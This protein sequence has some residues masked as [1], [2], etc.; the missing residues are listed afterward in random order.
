MID[1][2]LEHKIDHANYAGFWVRFFAGCVDL[3]IY[4]P[5]YYGILYES[6]ILTHHTGSSIDWWGQSVF[7]LTALF[8]YPF[9]L[10]NKWQASPGMYLFNFHIC[11]PHGQR[12][13]YT[14]AFIWGI[15]GSIGWVI[16]CAGVIY[17]QSHFDLYVIRDLMVSCTEQNVAP[18][19][20]NK[21]IETIV[22]MP[23]VN[24]IQIL[25][26]SL[27]LMIFLLLIWALSIGLAKDKTGFNNLLC[28]TRFVKGRA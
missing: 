2:I 7:L 23:F 28:G 14:R 26:A 11:T 16:C 13:T 15:V 3:A 25:S 1:S 6:A 18:E 10:A 22:N 9:F 20:C 21:E 17:V 8:T 5:L 27:I 12:I 19:D 4:A 24:F